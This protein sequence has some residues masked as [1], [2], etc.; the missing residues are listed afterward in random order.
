MHLQ[1]SM[2]TD[3]HITVEKYSG[4]VCSG[5]INETVSFPTYNCLNNSDA[6][7]TENTVISAYCIHSS[8]DSCFAGSETV[9]LEGGDTVALSEVRVGDRVL[10]A[11]ADGR[12]VFSEVASV[13]LSEAKWLVSL[14]F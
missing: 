11:A 14:C 2:Y 6:A 3:T 13:C 7:T 10:A 5:D 8:S 12:F 4:A 9:Q 1:P